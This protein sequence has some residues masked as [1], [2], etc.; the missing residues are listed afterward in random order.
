M[1]EPDTPTINALVCLVDSLP[2]VIDA[3]RHE[4]QMRPILMGLLQY[5]SDAVKAAP[6]A[7]PSSAGA[8]PPRMEWFASKNTFPIRTTLLLLSSTLGRQ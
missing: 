2:A 7:S 4:R 5:A 6:C 3:V 8:G 1:A